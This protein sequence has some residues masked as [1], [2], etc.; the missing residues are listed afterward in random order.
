[1]VGFFLF[2]D[3]TF[4]ILLLFY[5][6]NE[7]IRPLARWK[8]RY[9]NTTSIAGGFYHMFVVNGILKQKQSNLKIPKKE[10]EKKN[11]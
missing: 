6:L 10:K 4:G 3:I 8:N 2:L 1:L 11:H 7:E 9:N 5:H